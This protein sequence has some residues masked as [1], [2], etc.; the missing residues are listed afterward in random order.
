[1]F[2]LD[3]AVICVMFKTFLTGVRLNFALHVAIL[4]IAR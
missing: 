1:M 2:A 4:Q 3:V